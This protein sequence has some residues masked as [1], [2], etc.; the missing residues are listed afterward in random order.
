MAITTI[1]IGVIL[2]VRIAIIIVVKITI[3]KLEIKIAIVGALT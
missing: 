1:K 2:A 3:I